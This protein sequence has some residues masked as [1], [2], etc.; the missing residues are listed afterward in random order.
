MREDPYHFNN[1][2]SYAKKE[3]LKKKKES[4]KIFEGKKRR[5]LHL[6]CLFN[7]NDMFFQY[8]IWF[9]FHSCL[10]ISSGCQF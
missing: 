6:Y 1:I 3:D 8:L 9:T 5:K 7:A 4:I 10:N 2:H